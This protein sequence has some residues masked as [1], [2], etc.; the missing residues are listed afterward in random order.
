[1]TETQRII[2]EDLADLFMKRGRVLSRREYERDTD[3]PFSID[4]IYRRVGW[5]K[6]RDEAARL[7]TQ[8]ASKAE[9]DANHIEDQPRLISISESEGELS[10]KTAMMAGLRRSNMTKANRR[11]LGQMIE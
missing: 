7:M 4:R 8:D 11:A 5:A 2:I 9:E 10:K 1:M 3:K 6:A